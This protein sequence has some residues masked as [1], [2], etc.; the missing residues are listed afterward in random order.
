MISSQ[1]QMKNRK[2]H[3]IDQ[4]TWPD[5]NSPSMRERPSK[6][7]VDGSER[8]RIP[9]RNTAFGPYFRPEW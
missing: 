4:S 9:L 5:P 2:N 3:S 6:V 7:V 1:I 8:S